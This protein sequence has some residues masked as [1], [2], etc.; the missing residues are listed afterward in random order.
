MTNVSTEVLAACADLNINLFPDTTKPAA[1]SRKLLSG[2]LTGATAWTRDIPDRQWIVRDLIPAGG[3]TMLTGAGGEGKTLFAQQIASCVASGYP[4]LDRPTTRCTVLGL[5][6]E[7]DDDELSRRQQSIMRV[8]SIDPD[9]VADY[10]FMS[11]F[12]RDT[13]L[14]GFDRQTGAFIPSDLYTS[15]R[16]TALDLGARLVILD[17]STQMYGGDVND[18]STVVR[19]L[20][21]LNKLALEINGAVL[22]LGHVA[23]AEGSTYAGTTAWRDGVRQAMQIT[24]D[25]RPVP[26]MLAGYKD[27]LRIVKVTKSNYGASGTE[28]SMMWKEGAFVVAGADAHG[29]PE[30]STDTFLRNLDRLTKDQVHVS[31][32]PR[33][34][35]Y[36]PKIMRDHFGTRM[37]LMEAAMNS[38]MEDDRLDPDAE[39]GWMKPNRHVARGLA[40]RSVTTA[41]VKTDPMADLMAKLNRRADA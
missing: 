5:Y 30:T 18:R 27:S 14:G 36:A 10:H 12:G 7:D 23:K 19:F 37:D 4:V 31:A 32:S 39:L 20:Q 24:R 6:G 2:L 21:A 34:V 40:L 28:F 11:L 29:K 13:L 17:N 38:L 35:N 16:D 22:L 3:V 9:D 41:P 1:P 8:H 26:S 15:I 33:A 25:D